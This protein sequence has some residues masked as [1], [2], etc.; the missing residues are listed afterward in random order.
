LSTTATVSADPSKEGC[1]C[2]KA[3]PHLGFRSCVEVLAETERLQAE[4]SNLRR[5]FDVATEAFQEK[6]AEIGK[7]KQEAEVLR[8]KLT[9]L[10]QRPFA[11]NTDREE[12]P[13]QKSSDPSLPNREDREPKK[14]GAPKGHHGA[15]RNKPDRKPDRTIWVRPEQ[16]PQCD[17]HNI[18]PCRD[19]AEH[20]QE[21]LVIVRPI[22]TL[23]RKQ[24]GYC[25]DCGALFF[26]TGQGERPKSYIGPVAVAVAGYLR[27]AVKIP[28]D[29]VRR[30]LSGLWGLDL[31]AA[32]LVGFDKK[33]AAAGRP[34]YEQIADMVR[35]ST[36]INV[37]ETSW[38][39]G[40]DME[41]LWTFTNPNCVFFKIAPSRAGA[42]PASVLGEHYGG[43]LGSDCFS[44]YNTLEAQAKQKC[45]THYERAAD[46]LEKFYPVDQPATLF[47]SCLQDI[48][49]RARQAKRD[50]HDG[51]LDDAQARQMAVDFEEEL[52]QLVEPSLG[53]HDAEKLRNRLITHRNENFT[54]L[55]YPHV[56]ADNNRAERSLRPSVVM[57]KIT[58]GNNSETGTRNH[59]TLM[60][61]IETAKLHKAD[62]LEV[63]MGL[64][65]G[66]NWDGIRRILFATQ[67]LADQPRTPVPACPPAEPTAPE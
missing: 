56:D 63:M 19:I 17:S 35:Y 59:E 43:V 60:T 36:G 67:P 11:R 47:A 1:A 7:L 6:E 25:R 21:D 27:Y 12:E 45:L 58:Y 23:F 24:R 51:K 39:R 54:F 65:G 46:E 44:A 42:V 26:P 52:D 18:A 55:R 2:H 5:V 48:F 32:A 3:C 20:T 66:M 57:R 28:F 49:K 61:L 8:R 50:W 41:W 64:A 33:L 53:N 15:T 34:F 31:T 22:L 10:L 13:A 16:C 62:G 14:R 30:I 9:D 29:G 40:A 38:P 37:D 4:N